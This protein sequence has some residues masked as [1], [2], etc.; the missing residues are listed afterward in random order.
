MNQEDILK[1]A[2]EADCGHESM[3]LDWIAPN[4]LERFAALV[5]AKAAQDEREE[6]AMVCEQ[7][8]GRAINAQ[9]GPQDALSNVML[10][11]VAWSGFDIAAR[12]I[13]AR[14]Q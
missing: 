12:A 9:S 8:K 10:R 11:Q 3:T 5:A 4:G 14:G 2:R 1:M 6:C 7:Q 13:R